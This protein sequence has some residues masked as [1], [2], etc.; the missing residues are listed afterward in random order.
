MNQFTSIIHAINHIMPMP[1]ADMEL[2]F[3]ILQTKQVKKHDYLLREG[4]ICRSVYFLND[5]F[6][7]MYYVDYDGNEINY[8]F[9]SNNNFLVTDSFLK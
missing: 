6:F 1:E 7:R 9:T 8:R 5:G 4:D 2:L 3:P